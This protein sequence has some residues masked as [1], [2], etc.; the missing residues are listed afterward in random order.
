MSGKEYTQSCTSLKLLLTE[1]L[2]HTQT[3]THTHTQRVGW[4]EEERFALGKSEYSWVL[5]G[6]DEC[7]VQPRKMLECMCHAVLL[8]LCRAAEAYGRLIPAVPP[9]TA[10]Q[11][12]TRVQDGERQSSTS[13]GTK[14]PA[15]CSLA[16]LV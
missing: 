9:T 15:P 6:I 2:Q 11:P 3:R 4:R 13:P 10:Q 12:P 16:L 14:F 7:G 1:N 5:E 8:L